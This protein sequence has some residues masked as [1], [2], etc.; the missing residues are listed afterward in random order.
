[1][2]FHIA[3]TLKRSPASLRNTHP[4]SDIYMRILCKFVIAISLLAISV[5][6]V[7]AHAKKSS[8]PASH[9]LTKNN[10]K[11]LV[12][13]ALSEHLQQ[14]E[15]ESDCSHLVH[16]IYQTAG[17]PYQY[18]P[19]DDLSAGVARFYR[20]KAPLP[21]D[22]VVWR[23]HVGIVIKPSRH[24]FFSSLSSGPDTDNYNSPYWKRRGQLRFYR[25]IK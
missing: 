7:F 10:R 19:S 2:T 11:A 21:G 8:H 22:L 6:G 20:V 17:F 16:A 3:V 25:Y 15:D 1:M 14:E 18:A 4:A 12:A 23:G 24:T 9:H 13:I 5:G